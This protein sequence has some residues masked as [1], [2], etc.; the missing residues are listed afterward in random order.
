MSAV[1]LFLM[2]A[3]TLG[4]PRRHWDIS[5]AGNAFPHEFPGAA[6]LMMALAGITGLIAIIGGSMYLLITVYSVFLG[7]KIATPEFKHVRAK[8]GMAPAMQPVAATLTAHHGGIGAG[9]M[10]AP[11]TFALAM[12]FLTSFVLYYFINWKYLSTIW[13]LK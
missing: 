11:G 5:F 4:V 3:G 12:V 7:R 9:G 13:P 6:W 8:D 1:S 10:V 2:G